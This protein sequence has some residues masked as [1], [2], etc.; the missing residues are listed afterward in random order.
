M[1]RMVVSAVIAVWVLSG[2]GE[3]GE[4]GFT[5]SGTIEATEVTVSA[6]ARGEITD[7]KVDEGVQVTDG[8]LIATIDTRDL[9][10][11]KE[12]ASAGLDELNWNGAVLKRE[13][14]TAKETVQQA[15]VSLANTEKNRTRFANLLSENA[16]TVEQVDKIDTEYQLAESRKRAAEKQ[17]EVISTR[18]GALDATRSKIES[19]LRLIDKHIADGTVTSPIDGVVIDTFVERGE[20]VAYGSPICTI[21]DLKSVWLTIYVGEQDVGKITI[22]HKAHVRVDSH[23]DRE[24]PGTV[25]WISPKAEFTPKNVQTR[26]ARIDLVYA[27]KITIDNNEGIFKIGMPAEASIEGL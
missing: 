11:Q 10:L 9:D 27:V 1:K 5:G 17:I 21:A 20:V 15:V 7:L 26:D 3:E 6:Q 2:C 23:P 19:E 25:T 22:G 4:V 24:F 12:T 18:I 16:A 14:E 13:L 8:A